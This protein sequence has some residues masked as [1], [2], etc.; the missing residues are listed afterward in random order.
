MGMGGAP[1]S[2]RQALL[3]RYAALALVALLLVGVGLAAPTSATDA[4]ST[5]TAKSEGAGLAHIGARVLPDP[6]NPANGVECRVGRPAA[7]C[8][9]DG[10][11]GL[12]GTA[13]AA[14]AIEAIRARVLL[15]CA[16]E[17]V[18]PEIAVAIVDATTSGGASSSFSETN[19]LSAA[20]SVLDGW[21]VGA[22]SCHTGVALV[23]AI[24]DRR[25]ALRT[26]PGARGALG[27]A[28]SARIVSQMRPA[29]REHAYTDAV[30][31]AL[32][33]IGEALARAPGAAPAAPLPRAWRAA[34]Q[35]FLAAGGGGGVGGGGD[36][37]DGFGGAL[38][39]RGWAAPVS[40]AAAA[41]G[42]YAWAES[43]RRGRF[44]SAARRIEGALLDP[45]GQV[46]NACTGCDVCLR[47]PRD[48]A[49][50]N[51][52]GQL[53]CGHCVCHA[54]RWR[55]SP[56]PAATADA[57]AGWRLGAGGS[58]C[59]VCALAATRRSERAA[60]LLPAAPEDEDEQYATASAAAGGGGGGRRGGL[61]W[62]ARGV[63]GTV[64]LARRV[65]PESE[66]LWLLRMRSLGAS[67]CAPSWARDGRE[68]AA[69]G[70][71]LSHHSR[72]LLCAEPAA[73]RPPPIPPLGPAEGGAWTPAQTRIGQSGIAAWQDVRRHARGARRAARGGWGADGD[74]DGWARVPAAPS[75]GGGSSGSA[76]GQGKNGG[77]GAAA[78]W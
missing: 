46:A 28:E 45:S 9:P 75:F 43:A 72:A 1:R 77:G 64:S 41:V 15:P 4:S 67:L 60:G 6:T 25:V 65:S 59:P 50:P 37:G 52:R 14:A 47:A 33:R 51:A 18:S 78:S 31:I 44:C 16:G 55:Y 40:T 8:D 32:E 71:W 36:G 49:A 73:L 3:C 24:S 29:L 35:A 27:D 74:M 76:G 66:A 61:R 68:L 10:I 21:G 54:C 20:A 39:R 12:T 63:K 19:A 7:V 17:L 11:L 22:A 62:S 23:L 2:S 48:I 58:V 13:R 30:L 69:S 57:D 56:Q 42:C 26:G 38:A 70:S 53:R 34:A 5:A